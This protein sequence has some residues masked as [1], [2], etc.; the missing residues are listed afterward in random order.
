MHDLAIGAR[1][2][3]GRFRKISIIVVLFLAVTATG[4]ATNTKPAYACPL[5]ACI[6][7]NHALTRGV[8]REEHGDGVF[9]TDPEALAYTTAH[10]CQRG[11]GTRGW[12]AYEYCRHR[13][14]FIVFYWWKEH[15]LAAMMMMSE[16]LVSAAMNQMM[17]IGSFFDAEQQLE[18]QRAFQEGAAQ[19]HKD[20]HPSYEMCEIGTLTRSLAASQ[21]QGEF[22]AHVLSQHLQDR[23]LRN[24]GMA[25]AAGKGL[26]ITQRWVHF[27]KTFCVH[28]DNDQ[29]LGQE[30]GPKSPTICRTS[31]GGGGGNRP[32]NMDID[33]TE[34]VD[35]PN[36]ITIDFSDT[37]GNLKETAIFS[38]ASNLYGHDVFEYFPEAYFDNPSNH[39]DWM[40]VRSIV[41]KRSVAQNSFN[42]IVGMKSQGKQ[43]SEEVMP[44]MEKVLEQLGISDAT[45]RQQIIGGIIDGGSDPGKRP[46]YYAQMEFLTKA[47]YQRPEFYTAL[48]DKPANVDR[49]RTA[50]RA[51][52]LA[53]N[54]D[55]F[56]SKLRME[57][58]LAVLTE[59]EIQREQVLVQDRMNEAID[60][61]VE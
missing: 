4:L 34:T 19:V 33:Y 38:L 45:Q 8:A 11:T 54:M 27:R 50:M 60:T 2:I 32:R 21:R 29:E 53:Q 52:G 3:F 57:A 41:A 44:Y 61:G 49:K 1:Q 26:E 5:C 51:L 47:L 30:R 39:D 28:E 42:A 40:H 23:Q 35:H 15:I 24:R 18:A 10:G 25:S 7:A 16:Q 36:T 22:N 48:Y 20:Y 59:M 37:Q 31:A 56:K 17:I 12:I 6:S 43:E 14:E 46:S 55:L 9:Y 13:E 58:A